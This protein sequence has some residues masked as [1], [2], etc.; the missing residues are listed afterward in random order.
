MI[1]ITIL[2]NVILNFQSTEMI[3]GF[4]FFSIFILFI[5]T[6]AKFYTKFS[7]KLTHNITQHKCFLLWIFHC[8][9]FCQVFKIAWIINQADSTFTFKFL[10]LIILF[11][12]KCLQLSRL[13]A[14]CYIYFI[15][16][17]F[18]ELIREKC[19]EFLSFILNGLFYIAI[20]IYFSLHAV[21]CLTLK[22]F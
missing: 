17:E 8:F 11:C 18:C 4:N 9:Y 10:I 5:L 21:F 12:I 15:T 16:L 6:C 22:I 13:K 1:F 7:L 2:F 20:L 3:L 14:K 19:D